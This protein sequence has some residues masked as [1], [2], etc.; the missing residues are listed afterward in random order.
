MGAKYAQLNRLFYSTSYTVVDRHNGR[1]DVESAVGQG[2]TF[3]VE[4][5]LSGLTDAAARTPAG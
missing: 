3:T 1:I 2:S 4:L 5:P